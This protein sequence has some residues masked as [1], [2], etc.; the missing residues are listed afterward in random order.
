MIPIDDTLVRR[1]IATQF[2]QWAKLSIKPV[3]SAGIDH[4]LYRLDEEMVVRLP[5]TSSASIQIDKEQQWL[6]K[7]SINLPLSIIVKMI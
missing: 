4:A 1:L 3:P 5:R 7:L 6:P 2:P